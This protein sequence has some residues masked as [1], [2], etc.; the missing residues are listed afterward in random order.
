MEFP[1]K[2]KAMRNHAGLKQVELAERAGLTENKIQRY[3]QSGQKPKG[4]DALALAKALGVTT[5]YLLDDTLPFPPPDEHQ[6]ERVVLIRKL[7]GLIGALLSE[8][9]RAPDMPEGELPDVVHLPVLKLGAGFDVLFDSAN[10]PTGQ[11]ARDMYFNN[12]GEGKFFAG[13]LYGSSMRGPEGIGFSLGEIVI[14]KVVEPSEIASGD[15][16][17]ARTENQGLFRQA[18]V[19]GDRLRLRPLN[20]ADPEVVVDVADI[21]HIARLVRRVKEY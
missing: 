8:P 21:Q 7:E 5:D 12:L 3:E 15:F 14:F 6:S 1:E 16:V 17:H 10:Q 2:L 19:H 13:E 18:Y 9:G 4:E 20:P 11:K